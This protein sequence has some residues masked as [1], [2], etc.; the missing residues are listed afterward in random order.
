MNSNLFETVKTGAQVAI[1]YFGKN[2]VQ[3]QI[4]RKLAEKFPTVEFYHSF[5]E[6]LKKLN[7]GRGLSVF[8]NFSTGTVNF[9]GVMDNVET[10]AEWAGLHIHKSIHS[11]EDNAAMDRLFDNK[12]PGFFFFSKKLNTKSPEYKAFEETADKYKSHFVFITCDLETE[13]GKEFIDYV[14]VTSFPK[15]AIT[16]MSDDDVHKYLHDGDITHPNLLNLIEKF[17]KGDLQKHIKSQD[18]PTNDG[19]LKVVVGTTY[20]EVV[21][22]EQNHVFIEIYAPWCG[23]C[24]KFAPTYQKIAEELITSDKIIIAKIDGS[25]NDIDF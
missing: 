11:V 25:N 4:F 12:T 5:D 6:Q 1:V 16:I 19:P 21:N 14:G 3:Y 23:H 15:V 20:N 2:N 13:S 9:D 24:R 10:L 17:N 22:D 7:G 8:R 18:V